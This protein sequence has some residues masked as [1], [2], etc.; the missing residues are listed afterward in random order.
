MGSLSRE[1]HSQYW[2]EYKTETGAGYVVIVSICH[3]SML[4]HLY[5]GGWQRLDA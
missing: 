2:Q 3:I 4:P 1:N 5:C